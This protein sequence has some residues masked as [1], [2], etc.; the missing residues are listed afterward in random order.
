MRQTGQFAQTRRGS[1]KILIA[2]AIGEDF[3]RPIP[4]PPPPGIRPRDTKEDEMFD[5]KKKTIE[6]GGK[7]LTL[8]TGRAREQTA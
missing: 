5:I 4:C 8:E 1:P 6:W 7:S 3:G 2:C